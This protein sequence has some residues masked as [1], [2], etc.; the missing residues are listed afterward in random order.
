M[1]EMPGRVDAPDH[2]DR[3]VD[4]GRVEPG[5]RLVEQQHHRLGRDRPRHLQQLPL[6]QVERGRQGVRQVSEVDG[7]SGWSAVA[8][9]CASDAPVRPN[10]T[11]MATLSRTVIEANGLGIWYVRATPAW[12]TRCGGKPGDGPPADRDGAPGRL[13]RR[14]QSRFTSVVLPGTV[15]PDQADDLALGDR[16]SETSSSARTPPKSRVTPALDT[17]ARPRQPVPMIGAAAT[18]RTRAR[19][20]RA[21]RRPSRDRGG[22]ARTAGGRRGRVPRATVGH[23]WPRW[24]RPSI[25]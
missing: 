7:S 24:R 18:G 25:A 21:P 14:R 1:M 17:S 15:R 23:A 16:D 10:M 13:Q 8:R 6:V 9:A 2:R 4:L 11:A 5:Q 22:A 19:R 20:A 3:V 12:A